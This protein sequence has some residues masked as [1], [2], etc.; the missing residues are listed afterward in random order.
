MSRAS[1]PERSAC[2]PSAHRRLWLAA[3]ALAIL[4]G[5]C[6]GSLGAAICC[7]APRRGRR[8][9][10]RRSATARSRSAL[11]PAAVG[12]A[13]M[14]ASRR[15]PCATPPRWRSPNSNPE[16]PAPGQGRRRHRA[17]R[18]AGGAAGDRRR[19]RDHPRAAVRATVQRGRTGRAHARHSGDR[20]LDRRQRRR[21]RRLSAELPARDP[22]SSASSAT[23]SARASVRS[24]RWCPTTPMARVVEAAFKQ[25]VAR[26]GGR[27]VALERYPLD[28]TPDAGPGAHA[29]RRR[30][31]RRGCGLHP[32]RRRRRAGTVVQT[33][34]ASGVDTK[35]VQLLGTGLW[36]DPQD[37]RRSAACKAAG[38]PAPDPTGFRNF[39]SRY[40]APIRTGSR[41]AP[42]RSPTT[43]SRWSPRW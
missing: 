18:A 3:A 43:R 9:N 12:A 30:R 7:P 31:A 26:R 13:A 19:R 4:L 20:V 1:R 21:A 40:R 15:S 35:R 17:R 24:P 22:T 42:R 38:M 25:A 8:R 39:S 37:L 14:P 28:Q 11:D 16:H 23:P 2:A 32:G 5:G 10:R 27:V 36:E 34:I 29:S 41:C 33:L 6:S